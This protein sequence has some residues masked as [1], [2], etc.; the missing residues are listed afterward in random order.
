MTLESDESGD[1]PS[2]LNL[3]FTV[4]ARIRLRQR[5]VAS[6]DLTRSITTD[7]GGSGEKLLT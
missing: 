7:S 1:Q 2:R 5:R 3:F 6:L 4:C